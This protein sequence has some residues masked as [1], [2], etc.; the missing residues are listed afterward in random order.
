MKK[1][2]S[3]FA[4]KTGL[5]PGSIVYTGDITKKSNIH[6]S[7]YTQKEHHA[8]TLR[9][10]DSFPVLKKNSNFW[11]AVTGVSDVQF[12]RDIG[13]KFKLHSLV[14]EDIA[15]TG[16]RSKIEAYD[17][18]LFVTLKNFQH[19]GSSRTINAQQISLIVGDSFLL[20]FEES[21]SQ[22]FHLLRKRLE[23]KNSRLRQHGIAYLAYNILDVIVDHYF[24]SLEILTDQ[25]EHLEEKVSKNQSQV[26]LNKIHR[27]KNEVL[28][29]R[30]MTMPVLELVKNFREELEGREK[31]VVDFYL[32]DLY[33][34]CIQVNEL[35]KTALD[36]VQGLFELYFSLVGTRTNRIMQ[37]LT[38]ITLI[39]L[40]LTLIAGIYGMNFQYMPEL[41]WKW[42][43]PLVLGGMGILGLGIL[44]TLKRKKWL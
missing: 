3:L 20:S 43:Y 31:K 7:R 6:I 13:D 40:P 33:D 1:H 38:L 19:E 14:L 36:S 39:F 42:G 12:L 9:D 41:T 44:W 34:H 23:N 35:S 22:L 16:Q 4:Q 24:S 28:S 29:F 26:L 37:T 30:K 10:E 2:A 21:D 25:I 8:Q 11:I 18:Y 27:L 15:N 5:P 17:E 32:R